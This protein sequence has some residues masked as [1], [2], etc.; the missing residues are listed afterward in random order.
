MILNADLT[1]NDTLVDEVGIP[2][3]TATYVTSLIT[4]NAGFTANFVHM[5][6]W[7]FH[8]IKSGWTFFNMANL[9]K[10]FTL[11]TWVFWKDRGTRREEEKEAIKAN[12]DIDPHYKLMVNN[13]FFYP[14]LPTPDCQRLLICFEG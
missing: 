2:W 1:I 11:S 7:N 9:K 6:L 3:L 12:P 4:N 14:S 5:F 10:F 8:E 13:Q